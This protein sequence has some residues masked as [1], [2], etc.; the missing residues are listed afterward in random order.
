MLGYVTVYLSLTVIMTLLFAAN[1]AVKPQV[2]WF[3]VGIYA[4]LS[5]MAF[6]YFF[7]NDRLARR[8]K[9]R[10]MALGFLMFYLGW[11]SLV[12]S[13]VFQVPQ[14]IIMYLAGGM[15]ITGYT[16]G[17]LGLAH[18]SEGYYRDR[19]DLKM[20]TRTDDLTAL[21]NRRALAQDALEEQAFAMASESHLSLLVIDLDDFKLV[22]D[23]LG[24]EV[25]D[26]ILVQL[27]QLLLLYTRDTDKTYRWG[28]EEFVVMLPVTALFE[29]HQLA[30]KLIK[31]VSEYG[32][33]VGEVEPIRLTVSIGV[34][35]WLSNESMLKETF[36]RADEALYQAKHEGKNSAVS[37]D[38]KNIRLL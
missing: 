27:S 35:Q 22:N 10:F 30:N 26:R 2:D 7:I 5:L 8:Y 17:S 29:A 1:V 6:T 9:G 14:T 37:A 15:F 20:Q 23:K 28:G 24:H 25:G 38:F 33:N 34:A 19:N 32:F 3:L 31:K 36:K 4:I 12:M 18:W 16:L 11:L 13:M 21:S